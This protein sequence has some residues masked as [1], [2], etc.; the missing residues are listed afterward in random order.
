MS[1]GGVGTSMPAGIA[2]DDHIT[3]AQASLEVDV[4]PDVT[5]PRAGSNRTCRWFWL[6]ECR[7]Q[8]LSQELR[9]RSRNA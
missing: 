2:C 9:L 7:R 5:A 8:P 4:A 3:S 6:C 1:P